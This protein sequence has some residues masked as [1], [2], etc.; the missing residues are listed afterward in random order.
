[1]LFSDA[2]IYECRANII[3]S[4]V[5]IN[6]SLFLAVQGKA[7][8]YLYYI[9][10]VALGPPTV[11]ISSHYDTNNDS[12]DCPT[13]TVCLYPGNSITIK[14]IS[15]EML[16]TISGPDGM[17]QNHLL[18]ITSFSNDKEGN[19]T[20]SSSNICGETIS[21]I[22]LSMIS[23][24]WLTLYILSII[25]YLQFPISLLLVT[26]LILL[27]VVKLSLPVLQYPLYLTVI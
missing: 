16:Y 14:C 7:C 21:T 3:D 22:L 17:H 24:Y 18:V 9:S 1:M 27:L 12:G 8:L 11:T 6:D 26:I 2:G 20:C 19:Y 23:E 15:S 10:S 5:T 13:N 4:N 25:F